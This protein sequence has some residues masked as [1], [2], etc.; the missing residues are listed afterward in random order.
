VAHLLA[1]AEVLGGLLAG[2][3]RAFGIP[4]AVEQLDVLGIEEVDV[5]VG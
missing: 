4:L 1:A 3:R 5:E 2:Q